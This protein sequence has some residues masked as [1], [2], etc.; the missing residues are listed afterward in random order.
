LENAIDLLERIGALNPENEDLTALGRRLATL[1]VGPQIGKALVMACIFGCLDPVLTLT[2]ILSQRTIFVQPLNAKEDADR[3]KAEFAD[4][5]PSDHMAMLNAYNGW[6]EAEEQRKGKAFAFEN[7]LN[8]NQLQMA[9]DIRDQYMSLLRD[10]NLVSAHRDADSG[11]QSMNRNSK[12]WPVVK[13]CLLAG[14][15]PHVARI[16]MG[17]RRFTFYIKGLPPVKAHPGSVNGRTQSAE[18]EHR[19]VAYHDKVRTAGG[20]FLFDTSEVTPMS[21][22]MFGEASLQNSGISV[23]SMKEISDASQTASSPLQLK[24]REIIHEAI[25]ANGGS[26]GL[27]WMSRTLK[28]TR[29]DLRLAI[30]KVHPFLKSNGFVTRKVNGV[31]EIFSADVDEEKSILKLQD[32]VYF[33]CDDS[34][35]PGLIMDSRVA[36]DRV[37]HQTMRNKPLTQDQVGFIN[38]LCKAFNSNES[39]PYDQI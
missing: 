20:Y 19:W 10:A 15:Y 34:E 7:F 31:V 21:I 9:R 8:H 22:L 29:P 3:A 13:A 26:V 32:W 39:I 4:G 35:L 14:L 1:P 11:D 12:D 38:A 27:A 37:I 18:W 17:K 36:L 30:G 6:E 23:G 24:A 33:G 28:S 2:S 25:E 5:C 16:D